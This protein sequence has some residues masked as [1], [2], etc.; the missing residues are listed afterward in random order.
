MNVPLSLR[1]P[2]FRWFAVWQLVSQVGEAAQMVAINMVAFGGNHKGALAASVLLGFAP[3]ALAGHWGGPIVDKFPR[4]V[5]MIGCLGVLTLLALGL[6]VLQSQHELALWAL[7]SLQVLVGSTKGL[8]LVAEDALVQEIVPKKALSSAQALN[9]ALV[10]S[11]LML[12]GW[13]STLVDLSQLFVINAGSY[14]AIMLFLL[15]VKAGRE[16]QLR[17]GMPASMREAR[18]YLAR[19]ENAQARWALRLCGIVTLFFANGLVTKPL[20]GADLFGG[21]NAYGLLTAANG[22][23]VL[24]VMAFQALW[25]T[26]ATVH[27]LFIWSAQQCLFLIGYV[28]AP[29][30]PM[31]M[32]FLATACLGGGGLT[33][34]SKVM[35]VK[36]APSDI[37]GRLYGIVQ[38]V[39]L[40]SL[41]CS[42]LVA[43]GVAALWGTYAMGVGIYGVGGILV[44]VLWVFYTS[45]SPK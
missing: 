33:N 41:L 25:P 30:L 9:S 22:I 38:M 40:G 10:N 13:L 12:G 29:S 19:A 5:L 16:V 17:R 34:I 8:Y 36:G 42:N 3:Q 2:A 7:D 14:L 27:W 18:E 6:S 20:V 39:Y 32:A 1:I 21:G 35:V 44:G 37:W 24:I 11:G 28:A 4:R 23:G 15:R 45:R 31:S 43:M 26:P